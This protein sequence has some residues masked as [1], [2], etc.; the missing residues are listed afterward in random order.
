MDAIESLSQ[1]WDVEIAYRSRM[2]ILWVVPDAEPRT[3][4]LSVLST[5]G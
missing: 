1:M 3:T 5:R 2:R 4:N